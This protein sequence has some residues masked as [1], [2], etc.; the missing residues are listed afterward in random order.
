MS[1]DAKC[2]G[3]GPTGVEFAAELYDLVQKDISR[4]LPELLPYVRITLYDVAKRL[5]GSFDA[6]LAKYAEG[7]FKRRGIDLKMGHH[8]ER[9][10]PGKLHV[11]EQGE[12]MPSSTVL[13]TCEYH[14]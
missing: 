3:G 14:S 6:E 2:A 8:V 13:Q 11:K 1:T 7:K 4:S 9:V 5:L 10:E 12:G